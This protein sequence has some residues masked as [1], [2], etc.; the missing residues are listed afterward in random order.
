MSKVAW[1][2]GVLTHFVRQE[3]GGPPVEPCSRNG[4]IVGIHASCDQRTDDAAQH[5]PTSGF[6]KPGISRG[7]HVD[8]AATLRHERAGTLQHH[9]CSCHRTQLLDGA[10]SVTLHAFAMI[11]PAQ[12]PRCFASVWSNHVV[13]GEENEEPRFTSHGIESVRIQHHGHIDALEQLPEPNFDAVTETR[14]DN[15]SVYVATRI[16]EHGQIGF[17][18]L[19]LLAVVRAVQNCRGY[20]GGQL[21][22]YRAN[23]CHV[24]IATTGPQRSLCAQCRGASHASRAGDHQHSTHAGLV[25]VARTN[26]QWRP[27]HVVIV[28]GVVAADVVAIGR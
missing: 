18:Q 13:L 21:R 27:H 12:Q 10:E 8:V 20:G 3:I 23:A 16:D 25:G 9:G 6:G 4:R 1:N 28:A 24:H 26:R 14:S 11:S 15:H 5:I 19:R 22:C 17:R 2:V 7:V